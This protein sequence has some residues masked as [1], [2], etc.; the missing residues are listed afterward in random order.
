[1]KKLL[2]AAENLYRRRDI[3][4]RFASDHGGAIPRRCSKSAIHNLKSAISNQAERGGSA[5]RFVDELPAKELATLWSRLHS[6][7]LPMEV[8]RRQRE[9]VRMVIPN[10]DWERTSRK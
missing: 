1:M 2:K 3:S 9:L 8:N 10:S 7:G 6:D 5:F 4:R